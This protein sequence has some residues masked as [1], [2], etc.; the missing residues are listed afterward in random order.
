[1]KGTVEMS[2]TSAWKRLVT[3]LVFVLPLLS[4]SCHAEQE[5]LTT[6]ALKLACEGDFYSFTLQGLTTQPSLE[7][8]NLQAEGLF[9]DN[10]TYNVHGPGK[11]HNFRLQVCAT[12]SAVS[13]LSIAS[14]NGDA[15]KN[16]PDIITVDQNASIQNLEGLLNGNYQDVRILA[17]GKNFEGILIKSGTTASG[18]AFLYSVSVY[19]YGPNEPL[20]SSDTQI[21]AGTLIEGDPFASNEANPCGMANESFFTS[22][23]Q[24]ETA[25]FEFAACV[26]PA[27]GITTGFRVLKVVIKDS[28]PELSP[29]EQRPV[30]LEGEALLAGS[31]FRYGH[32]NGCDSFFINAGHA[33]YAATSAPI[34]GCSP[35]VEHAP[36]RDDDTR[37]GLLYTIKYHDKPWSPATELTGKGHFMWD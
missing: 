11:R 7:E 35:P 3:S 5:G 16:D 9:Y 27:P 19:K 4:I 25:Q 28:S 26:F 18:E 15:F 21:L 6:A 20:M 23:L 8:V 30:T 33:Q 2:H 17:F 13:L 32:H 12:Q 22:K 14:M 29:E 10:Q 1:M 24:L 34:G 36:E 37:T 31:A